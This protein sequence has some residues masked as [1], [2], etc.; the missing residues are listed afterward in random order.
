MKLKVACRRNNGL[1]FKKKLC[2]VLV[3]W[4]TF[5]RNSWRCCVCFVVNSAGL[6]GGLGNKIRSYQDQAYVDLL[7]QIYI[8]IRTLCKSPHWKAEDRCSHAQLMLLRVVYLFVT[9]KSCFSEQDGK[10]PSQ[11]QE[12][13][14]MLCSFFKVISRM[15]AYEWLYSTA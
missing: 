13:T 3:K 1:C 9:L 14:L 15:F 4:H 12:N 10:S 2:S 7:V 8:R 5:P 6:I 11:S